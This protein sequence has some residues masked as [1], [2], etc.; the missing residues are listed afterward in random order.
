MPD[1][2]LGLGSNLGDRKKNIE[3]AV[4]ALTEIQGV[5]YIRSS[6]IY[7]TEPWGNKEQPGFLNSVVEIETDLNPQDLIKVLKDIENRLGRNIRDKWM[8]REIDIDVLFYGNEVIKD[9]CLEIPHREIC[10]RRFILV[11]MCELGR[12]FRHPVIGKKMSELLEETKDELSVVLFST[13]NKAD[14]KKL[15]TDN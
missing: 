2:Y 13:N 6:S 4:T 3:G 5:K 8:E 10:N 7:E 14:N 11:P 12:D 9:G 15:K 1:V